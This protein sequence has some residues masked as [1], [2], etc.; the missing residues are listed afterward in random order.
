MANF[1]VRADMEI[2]CKDGKNDGNK[3]WTVL[4]FFLYMD[5]GQ[6]PNVVFL[7]E[8]W[9]MKRFLR[10]FMKTLLVKCALRLYS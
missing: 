5:N 4:F 1:T 9:K 6:C 10:F 2:H 3:M 8:G 7:I